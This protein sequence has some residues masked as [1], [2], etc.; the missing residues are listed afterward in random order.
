MQAGLPVE[1]VNTE[2][3]SG[4]HGRAGSLRLQLA[5]L[6]EL[7][8]ILQT[9]RFPN[10][11]RLA[12]LCAVSR[13]T[14]YRDL[15]TLEAAGIRILYHPDRQGYEL[16]R[17][18][19]LGPLQLDELEGL[20]LI[21]VSRSM[22]A[23]DPLAL[24]RHVRSGLAKV[25]GALSPPQRATIMQCGELLPD[26]FASIDAAD[27]VRAAIHQAILGGLIRR[28]IVEVQSPGPLRGGVITTRLAAY[29]LARIAGIWSLVGYS[30]FHGCVRT[31]P[32]EHIQK[33][34]LTDEP[35][36][37]PPRFRLDR[38]CRPE[39]AESDRRRRGDELAGLAPD[40]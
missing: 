19:L 4:S 40:E 23:D 39:E 34:E 27:S 37:I 1:F 2:F 31:F 35:Y 36:S 33:A 10:A 28:R 20:A 18:C 22:P 11:R 17:E 24:G 7:L 6:L 9:E 38:C 30:S 15:T 12:E 16:A 3:G 13:R 8:I 5:R 25:L 26:E 29:K 21:F 32:L 14:I